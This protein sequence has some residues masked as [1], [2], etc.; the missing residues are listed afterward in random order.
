MNHSSSLPFGQFQDFTSIRGPT[1]VTAQTLIQHVAY[2]LSDKLFTYSPHDFDLDVAVKDWSSKSEP[3]SHGYPTSVHPMQVRNGAGSIAL[4]YMFSNDFDL[5]KRHI[6]QTFLASSSSLQ[7]LRQALEQLSLLYSVANPFVAHVA[8][9]DYVGGSSGGLVTDYSTALSVAEEL[10]FGLVSSFSAYEAQHMSLLS[11]LLADVL[12]TLHIYDGVKVGRETTRVIDVLDQSG[13]S[14]AYKAIQ[15]QLAGP[16]GKHV[17][18]EGKLIRLLKAFNDELGTE[19]GLFEYHGHPLPD[20]VL[21]SFGTVESSLTSQVASSLAKDG[22]KVGVINVRVYRPF[23]EEEFLRAFPKSVKTVGVLGQVHDQQS[24]RDSGLHSNLYSDVLAAFTFADEW[25]ELPTIL[26]MKY[27]RDYRWTPISTAAAF[28]LVLKKPVLQGEEPQQTPTHPPL[29][30]LDP[31]ETQQ[32]TFWDV[33]D[34][35]A[36]HASVILGQALAKDSASNVTTSTSHDNISQGGSARTD[37]RKSARTLEAP[38]SIDSADT[39][40]VGDDR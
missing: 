34:S 29:Q 30:I 17:D 24:I 14:S 33:D 13:L 20:A 2:A 15:N 39:V 11:T 32:Y 23:V 22:H 37:I 26:D 38:Y 3:N 35:P 5:K 8:A 4:G 9:A 18:N 12:P 27:S 25:N 21:V 7:F 6:P 40:F 10:G 36:A 16:D 1:Y 19:Y 28:Q 31:E